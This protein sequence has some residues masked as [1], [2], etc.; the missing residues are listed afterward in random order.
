[1]QPFAGLFLPGRLRC[2]DDFPVAVRRE[3]FSPPL[4]VRCCVD[5]ERA[6]LLAQRPFASGVLGRL[7]ARLRLRVDNATSGI[8]NQRIR[9]QR[10]SRVYPPCQ[11]AFWGGKTRACPGLA[12][13]FLFVAWRESLGLWLRSIMQKPRALGCWNVAF[14]FSMVG[15]LVLGERNDL[16]KR[17]AFDL[18]ALNE[19]SGCKLSQ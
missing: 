15:V 9:N 4:Q 18:V 16:Y 7:V 1:M 12:L 6:E 10:I 8:R 11:V 13:G 3:K 5:A 17:T 19:A 14:W 2:C